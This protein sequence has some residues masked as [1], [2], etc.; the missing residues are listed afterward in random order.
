MGVGVGV[1]VGAGECSGTCAGMCSS[2]RSCDR[3]AAGVAG[4]SAGGLLGDDSASVC[5]LTEELRGFFFRGSLLLTD[6][7]G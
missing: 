3:A 6:G 2:E 1:G 7:R 5:A 4:C